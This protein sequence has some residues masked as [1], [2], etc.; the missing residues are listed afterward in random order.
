MW[1]SL[2]DNRF[3]RSVTIQAQQTDGRTDKQTKMSSKHRINCIT[4]TCK[5]KPLTGKTRRCRPSPVWISTASTSCSACGLGL[6]GLVGSAIRLGLAAVTLKPCLHDTTG[7]QNRL[8]NR[9]DNRLNVC[10]HDAAGC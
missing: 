8:N 7:C 4:L 5:I 9:L 3:S 2:W 6:V 1:R 10:L